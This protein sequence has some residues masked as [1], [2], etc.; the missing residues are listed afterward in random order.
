[1]VS[2]TLAGRSVG[3]LIFM[4]ALAGHAAAGN[5]GLKVTGD[6]LNFD[7]TLVADPREPDPN[8]TDI[9][10]VFGTVIDTYSYLNTRTHAQPFPLRFL[11]CDL[12][13]G[14]QVKVTFIGTHSKELIFFWRLATRPPAASRLVWSRRT[15]H[16]YRSIRPCPLLCSPAEQ[17][18]LCSTVT[19]LE[20]LPRWLHIPYAVEHLRRRRHSSLIIPSR[21]TF[22]Y[23]ITLIYFAAGGASGRMGLLV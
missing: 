2:R 23:E 14:N 4:M 9:T 10:L 8:T 19:L 20:N 11:K 1:M 3:M 6:N 18:I 16:P 12:S 15:A 21:F 22:R 5:G 17:T 13:L 7:R